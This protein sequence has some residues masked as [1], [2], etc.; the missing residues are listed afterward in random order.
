MTMLAADMFDNRRR[1][2]SVEPDVHNSGAPLPCRH[3]GENSSI[4]FG[5]A[6]PPA[7]SAPT[8]ASSRTRTSLISHGCRANVAAKVAHA[9]I[10]ARRSQRNGRAN[11]IAQ[12]AV[13]LPLG[14]LAARASKAALF[15]ARHCVMTR[16]RNG[17]WSLTAAPDAR[18]VWGY[19][20]SLHSARL[21]AARWRRD[22]R[23]K[24][25]SAAML[26]FDSGQSA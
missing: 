16:L 17:G 12:I 21:S 5:T 2:D 15:P 23:E 7:R 3:C 22:R 20:S 14:G 18:T 6:A 8:N 25:A 26:I 1:L 19:L 11:A 9:S 4:L 13:A 24:I 10:A